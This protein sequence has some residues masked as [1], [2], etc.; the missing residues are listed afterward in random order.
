MITKSTS[1]STVHRPGYLDYV[2]VKRFDASGEV[3][4]EHRFLGLFTHTAYSAN[5]AD[6]PL[7]RHKTASVIR[8]VNLP[9]GGHAEKQLVN[10]LD[11]YPRDELL[12]IGEDDLVRTATGILHL[13]DR[14]RFRLFLRRD[15]FERCITCLIY[16]PRE[17]YRAKEMT[18]TRPSQPGFR[19]TFLRGPRTV[20]CADEH[21]TD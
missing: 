10:I 1:R 4:G 19:S 9:A 16:A 20:C 3:C 21:A 8:R 11:N 12:Q 18:G 7:L 17:N 13:G 2:G 14:Q 6:I 5:P 15:P